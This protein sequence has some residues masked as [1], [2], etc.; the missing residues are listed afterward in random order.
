M[1][2]QLEEEILVEID[3]D[4]EEFHQ[5]S[6][7]SPIAK[8]SARFDQ[9]AKTLKKICKP[10]TSTFAEINKEVEMKEAEVELGLSF[11]GEGN[12]FITKAKGGANLKVTI[13]FC[14]PNKFKP[15]GD[16]QETG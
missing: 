10:I 1:I 12:I 8:V 15:V 2:I 11:E 13:K 3:I 4:E 6:G 16:D 9:V 5:I 14:P 7:G